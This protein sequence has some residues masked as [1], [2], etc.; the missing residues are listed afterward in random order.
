MENGQKEDVEGKA[1]V[2]RSAGTKEDPTKWRKAGVLALNMWRRMSGVPICFHWN[3]RKAAKAIHSRLPYTKDLPIHDRVVSSK[4]PHW[5]CNLF[6]K[7]NETKSW[8][9]SCYW[10][11][12]DW[13]EWLPDS[14]KN[15][16][17]RYIAYIG[18]KWRPRTA[19]IWKRGV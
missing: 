5:G 14:E 1:G 4:M 11:V 17:V 15:D 19:K 2:E 12:S 9:S 13:C 7:K 8:K 10:K 18:Y 16:D 3:F 6:T